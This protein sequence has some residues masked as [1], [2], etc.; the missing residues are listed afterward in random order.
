[1]RNKGVKFVESAKT[2]PVLWFGFPPVAILIPNQF[3]RVIFQI[4][5]E[6]IIFQREI[7][8]IKENKFLLKFIFIFFE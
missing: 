2:I 5:G 4:K 6:K 1:M 3:Q 7:S 8:Q